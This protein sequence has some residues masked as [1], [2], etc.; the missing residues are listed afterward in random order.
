M[1]HLQKMKE[2][3]L[4][5]TTLNNTLNL[6]TEMPEGEIKQTKQTNKLVIETQEEKRTNH[7]R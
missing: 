2:T 3:N 5:N 1:K 4:S 6:N 7:Y